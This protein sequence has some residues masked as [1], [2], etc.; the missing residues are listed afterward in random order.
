MLRCTMLFA[1]SSY[2]SRPTFAV[3]R[4]LR[5]PNR[6]LTWTEEETME[7]RM[8]MAVLAAVMSFG[9]LAAIVFGMI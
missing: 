7:L 9:F 1:W 8:R 5:R 4:K 6:G 2:E 3:K